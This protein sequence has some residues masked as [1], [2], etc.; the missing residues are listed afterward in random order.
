MIIA[1][2]SST[3]FQAGNVRLKNV[4]LEKLNT[5]GAVQDLA[6][7]KDIDIIISKSQKNKP[8]LSHSD[9][10]TVSA[11][12]NQHSEKNGRS[13]VSNK[14]LRGTS[15]AI[16]SKSASP[17]EISAKIYDTVVKAIENLEKLNF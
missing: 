15:F 17:E 10:Y 12:K 4:N 2:V 14:K 13:Y 8:A 3:N 6:K 7:H 9:I 16:M 11:L 5:Y 1:S